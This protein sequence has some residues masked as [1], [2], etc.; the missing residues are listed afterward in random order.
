MRLAG[1][2]MLV[3][4]AAGSAS[5]QP[6]SDPKPSKASQNAEDAVKVGVSEVGQ[7][8]NR[9]IR[10]LQGDVQSEAEKNARADRAIADKSKD[11]ALGAKSGKL[12]L[13]N[14]S[15]TGGMNESRDKAD[16]AMSGASVG[17]QVGIASGV[18]G[19]G[20]TAQTGAAP[21]AQTQRAN[22]KVKTP[23]VKPCKDCITPAKP[24]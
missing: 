3:A 21:A 6:V 11:M 10:E 9:D 20:V 4:L 16:K 18:Q 12:K 15:I 24:H 5:A 19:A 7:D 23:A 22:D 14:A 8:L 13:D 17:L 2:A 1:L